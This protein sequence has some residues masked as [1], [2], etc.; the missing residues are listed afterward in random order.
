MRATIALPPAHLRGSGYL[1]PLDGVRGVAILMVI[2]FH[3]F[4]SNVAAGGPAVRFIGGLLGYGFFGVDL[5]FVLSGFLITGILVDSVEGPGFF[6]RFYARRALRIFPLYYGLL[7]LLFLLTPVLHLQWH[8]MGWLMLAY[9]QNMNKGI[10]NFSPGAG[11]A[12]N[13]LWSLA[14]EEQFY[15]AWP[16]VI[17]LVRGRRRLLWTTLLL[18]AASLML[19]IWLISKGVSPLAIH[20]NTVTRAD[21]LLLGGALALL[22][23]SDYWERWIKIAPWGFLLAAVTVVLSIAVLGAESSQDTSFASRLWANG[24]RYTVLALGF[25]CL[26]AWSL[27]P[28][29]VCGWLFE[30]R[31]LRFFGKY[32]YGIYVIHMVPLGLLVG[33]QRG[34]IVRW[35]H[36]KLLA[37]VVSGG[38]SLA[39]AIGAAYLSFHFYEKRFLRLKAFF[40]YAPKPVA[41]FDKERAGVSAPHLVDS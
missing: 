13:H 32:S 3:A 35:T 36:S 23:R 18:S 19:R 38:V 21:S 20:L 9:L 26:I 31:W 17:F 12:L 14:I 22:Y 7:F 37:V 16:A 33:L 24:P 27:K 11:L 34:S 2:C 39:L 41:A 29:S 1:K 30:R 8:G 10:A 5:F 6:Q 25:G 4:S 40:D 15:L 28:G